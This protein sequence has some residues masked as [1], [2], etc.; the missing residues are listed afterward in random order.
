[1]RGGS[2]HIIAKE[3]E[4]AG[5]QMR[6]LF[7][8]LAGMVLAGLLSACVALSPAKDSDKGPNPVT[9]GEIE[10]TSLEEPAKKPGKGK[11]VK[12]EATVKAEAAPVADAGKVE[13]RPKPRPEDKAEQ[14]ATA[15]EKAEETAEPAPAEV[16]PEAVKTPAQVTC[17]KKGNT[18]A[19][20]GD[21]G[22]H[23]CA[24][25]TKDSGKRCTKGTECEGQCL[26][27][28]GTCAPF[29]PLLGCNE[30][31]QDDGKRMTLCIE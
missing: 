30:I 19:K 7:P 15:P 8:R 27:R 22:A 9:G 4:T 13:K 14:P 18:W 10:V 6:A 24:K 17:E 12:P 2:G 29:T 25:R 26:A 11:P 16:K 3:P 1:M 31:F 20:L 5:G 21:S 28:S 23:Y